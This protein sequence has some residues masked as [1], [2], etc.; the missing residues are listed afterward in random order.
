MNTQGQ[1]THRKTAVYA[2]VFFLLAVGLLPT[3][4]CAHDRKPESPPAATIDVPDSATGATAAV[5]AFSAALKAK[6][7]E[8]IRAA[9]DP[10]VIVLEAGGAERD[11]DEYMS[12]HA[13]AD[14]L[15]MATA[16]VALLRRTARV[17]G[18][19]AWVASETETRVGQDGTAATHLGTETMV[20]RHRPEGWKIVHI[21]WS[22][23]PKR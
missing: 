3:L 6:D 9:L 1:T 8:A 22:S 7:F 12:H 14:A 13:I 16:D 4:S 18:D 11:R 21:H 17:E 2:S 10:A 15:F 23:R 5:D 20:L 19:I